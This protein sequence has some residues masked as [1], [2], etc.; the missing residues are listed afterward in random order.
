MTYIDDRRKRKQFL[1]TDKIG[2]VPIE[3]ARAEVLDRRHAISVHLSKNETQLIRGEGVI[4][5]VVIDTPR[6]S[7]TRL[8]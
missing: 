7:W 5:R 3:E 4:R 1:S 2:G 6:R 8:C